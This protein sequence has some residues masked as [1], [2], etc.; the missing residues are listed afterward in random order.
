MACFDPISRSIP[1]WSS[2]KG[3]LLGSRA[4]AC[5]PRRSHSLM[6]LPLRK[7]A[8]LINSSSPFYA[9]R[10]ARFHHRSSSHWDLHHGQEGR[11][12]HQ[13]SCP[14]CLPVPTVESTRGCPWL[15]DQHP[16]ERGGRSHRGLSRYEEGYLISRCRSLPVM[17]GGSMLLPTTLR[18]ASHSVCCSRINPRTDS[19]SGFRGA[20][21]RSMPTMVAGLATRASWTLC[22]ASPHGRALRLTT[23]W[24]RPMPLQ[25]AG[26]RW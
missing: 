2:C 24:M 17:A 3:S 16:F 4:G 11:R 9:Q 13:V 25:T 19:L 20:L 26:L 22:S 15:R 10:K 8:T 14:H 21:I 23:K 18:P 12:P 1:S 7:S 6:A 5:W